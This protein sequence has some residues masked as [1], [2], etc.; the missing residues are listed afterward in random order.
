[1]KQKIVNTFLVLLS[2]FFVTTLCLGLTNNAADRSTFQNAYAWSGHPAKDNASA[3]AV[4]MQALV[5][6]GIALGTGHIFYV[7][8]NVINEGNGSSWARA[9]DTLDEA[10]DLCTTNRGDVILVAQGHTEAMGAAADEVDIDLHGITILGMGTGTLRPLF[11]WT[12]HIGTGSFN[13]DADNITIRNCVF[14]ANVPDCNE[15][16][17]I[18]AGSTDIA[19]LNC[20]FS[21]TTANTDE[22]YACID[23]IGA[24]SDRLTVEGCI[25]RQEAGAAVA[26]LQ[27]VDIDGIIFRNNIIQGT[28]STAP[29]TASSTA[30]TDMIFTDNFFSDPGADTFNLVAASTGFVARNIIA[31]EATVAASLDIGNCWSVSNVAILDDDVG[32]A[33]S[34]AVIDEY[35][36]VTASTE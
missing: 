27:L 29:I 2:L 19:I 33:F 10:V 13:I 17:N 28:Y 21:V 12:S 14:N 24:A 25:F 7:D 32:G 4:E 11:D 35:T 31:M 22:F 18:A 6:A 9:K 8:S 36:S 3:W 30:S 5:E 26:A 20:F 15:A 34:E 16:I 1:M 23:S